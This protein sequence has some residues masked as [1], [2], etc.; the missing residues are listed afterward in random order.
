MSMLS[1]PSVAIPLYNSTSNLTMTSDGGYERIPSRLSE[2]NSQL[3]SR[4]VRS[5]QTLD[6]LQRDNVHLVAKVSV[7]YHMENSILQVYS[8]M[9]L[10]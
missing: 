8:H 7:V 5:D 2:A 1:W 10:I 9:Y 3:K 6:D 4:L